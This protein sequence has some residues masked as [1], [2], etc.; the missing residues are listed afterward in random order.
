M[1]LDTSSERDFIDAVIHEAHQRGWFV[2]HDRPAWTAMG[3]R[4]AIQGEPGFPDLVLL[5]GEQLLYWELKA[6]NGRVSPTQKAWHRRM[7]NAGH[8][9]RVLR[10]S[11]RDEIERMLK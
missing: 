4:T 10:P 8:P 7:A 11:D 1:L 2:H 6:K 9:V 5:K 3:Y